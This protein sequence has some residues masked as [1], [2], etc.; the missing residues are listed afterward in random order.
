MGKNLDEIGKGEIVLDIMEK[1]LIIGD[2]LLFKDCHQKYKNFEKAYFFRT[3]ELFPDKLENRYSKL[4][5][6]KC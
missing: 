4:R 6:E 2:V 3:E 5:R 1:A